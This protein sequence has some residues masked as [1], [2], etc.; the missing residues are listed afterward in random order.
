MKEKLLNNLGFKVLAVAIAILLWGTIVNITDPADTRKITNVTVNMINEDAL[1]DK[2]YTY[3]ILEGSKISVDVKG[4]T[5]V[6]QSLSSNDIYATADFST[7]SPV[8]DY[9]TI[10]AKCTKAGIDENDINIILKT[11][12]VKINIENRETKS[13]DIDILL[14]GSPAPG[15]YL[16]DADVSPVSI[17]ITGA[18]SMIESIDRVI[19][20][21]DVEGAS[22]DV[23]ENVKLKLYDV[24]GNVIDDT[25]L[26]FSRETARIKVPILVR[27]KVPVSYATIGYVDENYTVTDIKYDIEEVEIA[28]TSSNIANITSID[29]PAELVDLTGLTESKEYSVKIGQYVPSYVKL[30]SNGNAKVNVQVEPLIK[31]N[32][33]YLTSAIV[34]EGLEEGYE[35]EIKEDFINV[36]Y[37]GIRANIEKLADGKIT[38]KMSLDKLT[39]GEHQVLVNF[40]EIEGCSLFSTEN[41]VTVNISKIPDKDDDDN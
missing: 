7:I 22:F 15:Y 3:E 4:P 16:G 37:V 1:L 33:K 41:Y 2:G 12:Q 25:N 6:I 23:S 9:I 31:Q 27:K 35:Y 40:D 20:G 18:E 39:E 32:Q 8:S 5:S 13:F 26:M 36:V 38:A 28:G 24:E 29:I 17:K 21:Y 11:N 30:I 10:E 19:A 14:S 34:I